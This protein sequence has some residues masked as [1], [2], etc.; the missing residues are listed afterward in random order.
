MVLSMD[1]PGEQSGQS[2]KELVTVF[3]LLY[4]YVDFNEAFLGNK[5]CTKCNRKRLKKFSILDRIVFLIGLVSIR[6]FQ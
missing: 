6:G 5:I 4:C 1:L 3:V 2:K